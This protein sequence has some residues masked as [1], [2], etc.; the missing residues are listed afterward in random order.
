MVV[1]VWFGGAT[2]VGGS[3]GRLL[4]VYDCVFVSWAWP[5]PLWWVRDFFVLNCNIW[6]FRPLGVSDFICII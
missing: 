2:I 6:A 3:G 4:K 5:N 1:G